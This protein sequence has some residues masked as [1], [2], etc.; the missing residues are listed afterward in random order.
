MTNDMN[1]N[2]S[3]LQ[4]EAPVNRPVQALLSCLWVANIAFLLYFLVKHS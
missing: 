3:A 1:K 4:E 2:V